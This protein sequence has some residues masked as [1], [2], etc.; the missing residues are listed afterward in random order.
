LG[1]GAKPQPTMILVLFEHLETL[2]LYF[3][4]NY[5]I[6]NV[7]TEII[8]MAPRRPPTFRIGM[9]TAIPAR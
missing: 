7:F 8:G 2:G 4:D 3:H 9:A 1:S 6:S 5:Y